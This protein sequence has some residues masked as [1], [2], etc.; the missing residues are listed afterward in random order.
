[1]TEQL[2]RRAR[3]TIDLRQGD[4]REVMK[5]LADNSVDSIVCDPPYELSDDGKASASR[6]F[7]EFMFPQNAKIKIEST[8][9]EVLPLLIT[10]VLELSGVSLDPRPA[11]SVEVG[12]VTLDDNTSA[13]Q[14]DVE[15]VTKA[16]VRSTNSN[17]RRHVDAQEPE[18]LGDFLLECANSAALLNALNSAGCGFDAGGLGVGFRVAPSSLPSLLHGRGVIPAGLN[19][20]RAVDDAL[21]VIVGTTTAAEVSAVAAFDMARRTEEKLTAAGA[22]HFLGL[23]Q[24]C[25]AKAVRAS[26]G[27]SGLSAM[28]ESRRISVV[29][30]ATGRALTFNL[31]VHPQNVASKGFMGKAWDGSKI[32]FDVEVWREA[33]RVLKPG[34]HLVAFS[35]TRTYHRMVVAIEDAG[36]EIRDQL[37]WVYGSGM[38]KSM[39][40]SKQIDKAAGV[41]REVIDQ[42]IMR[43][44]TKLNPHHS[45]HASDYN[46]NSEGRR[47][48]AY[49]ASATRVVGITKPA[50]EDAQ[51]W[52]GW[53]TG[54]KPCWEPICLA[55]KPF[56]TTVTAN[57]LIY[58]T[59]AIN[60]DGCRVG[61]SGGTAS[62]GSPPDMLNKVYGKGMG[63]TGSVPVE[64][65]G[66][67]PGNIIHDGSD[68]V[69][70]AFPRVNKSSSGTSV[71]TFGGNQS[72]YEHGM[73]DGF[74]V[75]VAGDRGTAARFFY[76]AKASKA[77]RGGSGNSHA[78]VKPVMLMRYLCR[79]ITPPG[80]VVLDPFMGS[81]STM[82][83]ARVEGFRG[84]G[85]DLHQEHVDIAQGRLDGTLNEDCEPDQEDGAQQG[86]FF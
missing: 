9:E 41:A 3:K 68:E 73:Q 82:L 65:L 13:G 85:I 74:P 61:A 31:V 44:T 11:T 59:G 62:D 36:F 5:T 19:D 18:H 81:G 53:G 2:R 40:I 67:W 75:T 72:L 12:S 1:M 7:L 70:D 14:N 33:L 84:V 52:E 25:G 15:H 39:D 60:I 83:A 10:K 38:P 21:A 58:G 28:L 50:T 27:A 35:G 54:L 17:R 47:A 8:R 80:G 30:D 86:L 76:S 71:R 4:C 78:T 29:C 22:L 69:Q 37:A 64:G 6:V 55:R 16:P 63:G 79:L 23:A 77:D 48:K 26:A 57:V 24:F 45:Q 46:P 66:R 20:V 32:A 34:G 49:D 42:R 51:E 56:P 43:D